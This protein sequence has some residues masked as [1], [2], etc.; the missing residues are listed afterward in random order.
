MCE[1]SDGMTLNRY[2]MLIG[3]IVEGFAEGDGISAAIPRRGTL[4][5]VGCKPEVDA[6]EK[7]EARRINERIGIMM[8][9][10]PEEDRR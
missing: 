9:L 3:F 4:G 1:C 7:M 5:A 10:R 8:I 2:S 6:I